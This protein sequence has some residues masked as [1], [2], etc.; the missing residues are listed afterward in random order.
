MKEI[1]KEANDLPL[2][3]IWQCSKAEPFFDNYRE[4]KYQRGVAGTS[5]RAGEGNAEL[6][7]NFPRLWL[8]KKVHPDQY[9]L[10]VMTLCQLHGQDLQTYLCVLTQGRTRCQMRVGPPCQTTT[11]WEGFLG[12]W[13]T[14]VGK[15]LRRQIPGW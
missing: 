10:A 14:I 9:H 11:I 2:E 3:E 5:I 8:P 4:E 7:S 13:E 6:S 1:S 15:P 12:E